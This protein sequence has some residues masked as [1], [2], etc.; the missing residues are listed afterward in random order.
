MAEGGEES[1][2]NPGAGFDDSIF[3]KPP[4]SKLLC[5]ICRKVSKTPYQTP[6]CHRFCQ[7]CL[8]NLIV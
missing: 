3:V 2:N 8:L 6:C 7:D 4:D 5:T 1:D